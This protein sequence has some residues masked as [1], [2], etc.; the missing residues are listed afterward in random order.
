MPPSRA[1]ASGPVSEPVWLERRRSF[2]PPFLIGVVSDSHVHKRG[3]RRF[4]PEV[5]DLLQ[6][7]RVDLILHAG[8]ANVASVLEL[9]GGVAPVIAV[10]GNND[11]AEVRELA[12]IAVEFS[13]GRFRFG[14]LHGHGGVSARQVARDRFAEKVDCAVYGHSHIP[15]SERIGS[16][17]FFNPGSVIERRWKPDFG[18]GLIHVEPDRCTPE[19]ILFKDPRELAS[20]SPDGGPPDSDPG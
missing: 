4:P 2:Q 1:P 20:V 11:D 14:L 8:D 9:L 13:V 10:Q 7:F 18:L 19:M 3:A 5:L 15:M 17:V 16:T 12:P 6:R